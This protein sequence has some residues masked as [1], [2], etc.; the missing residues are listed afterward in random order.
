MIWSVVIELQL[1]KYYTTNFHI[2]NNNKSD[3]PMME[4][5]EGTYSGDIQDNVPHGQGEM[6]YKEN[7]PMN[8][9]VYTGEWISGRSHEFQNA[10]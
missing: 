10:T 2:N 7:D 6:V 5:D 8:R 1:S 4:V 3:T 9:E